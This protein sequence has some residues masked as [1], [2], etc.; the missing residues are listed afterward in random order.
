MNS[1]KTHTTNLGTI[2]SALEVDVSPRFD[3][4]A[5]PASCPPR[6]SSQALQLTRC[7]DCQGVWTYNCTGIPAE[8]NTEPG[9][10]RQALSATSTGVV[11][12]PFGTVSAENAGEV[13]Y[14]GPVGNNLDGLKGLWYAAD[15]MDG[16]MGN[17]TLSLSNNVRQ[18]GAT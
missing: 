6:S 1:D 9:V 7:R 15:D 4:H 14:F 8:F 18:T 11:D 3:A 2:V 17:L 5:M 13:S 16:W 10:G 12:L